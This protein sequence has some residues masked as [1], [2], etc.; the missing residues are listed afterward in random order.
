M[1]RYV[2]LRFLQVLVALAISRRTLVFIGSF[3]LIVYVVHYTFVVD[4][5]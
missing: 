5:R 3:S 2:Y 4:F 1:L